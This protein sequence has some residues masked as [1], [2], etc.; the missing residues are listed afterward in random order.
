[1]IK[2]GLQKPQ[3]IGC[4]HHILD[5]ILRHVLDSLFDQPTTRPTINYSFVDILL[6]NY[7]RLQK[8]YNA[9]AVL[10]RSNN[11]AW[12]DDFKFLFELCHS[13]EYYKVF[14]HKFYFNE[15]L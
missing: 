4:Q 2:K 15:F 13:V 6:K 12:R 5:R 9:T 3:Y 11:P 14:Q 8:N 10:D 7:E 1:M